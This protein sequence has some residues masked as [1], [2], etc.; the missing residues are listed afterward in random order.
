MQWMRETCTNVEEE[1]KQIFEPTDKLTI[2]NRLLRLP[3][4]YYFIKVQLSSLPNEVQFPD[5]D[6]EIGR[7][8]YTGD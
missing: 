5:F 1:I 4:D 8:S 7:P 6:L 3:E 2:I